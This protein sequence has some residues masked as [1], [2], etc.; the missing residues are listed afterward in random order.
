MSRFYTNAAH[1]F[2]RNPNYESTIFNRAWSRSSPFENTLRVLEDPETGRK[3]YLIGTTNSS[4][5][6][7]KRTE[8]LIAEV[9]PES[10]HVNTCSLWYERVSQLNISTQEQL[11]N[12]Q[13]EFTDILLYRVNSWPNNF[14]GVY[15][16]AR[17]YSWMLFMNYYLNFPTDFNPWRPGAE[18]L[19]GIKAAEKVGAKVN[20]FGGFLNGL[21][22]GRMSRENTI[23]LLSTYLRSIRG[24]PYSRWRTEAQDFWNLLKTT[25]GAA[26]SENLDSH[27]VSWFVKWLERQNPVMKKIM[28]D[29]ED[30]RMFHQIF[31]DPA[32]VS[33]AIVNHWHLPGIEA[34][35]RANTG[36]SHQGE[37]INPIGDMPIDEIME[38]GVEGDFLRAEYSRKSKTEPAAWSNYL[39]HYHKCVM[40]PER[41][42][43]VFFD[44]AH[45]HH[46]DHGLF[47]GENGAGH[48][49]GHHEEHHHTQVQGESSHAV[50]AETPKKSK[51]GK[52]QH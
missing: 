41:E 6:L 3:V 52:K 20:Y 24:E 45:D 18:V 49:D 4:T 47:N 13:G 10:I 19:W 31:E 2:M 28:V 9:K 34:M 11:N 37:R 22:V 39:T 8:Q 50:E 44:G 30:E 46:M 35:W 7:A 14:R 16:K 51:K 48:G 23:G 27:Y 25:G 29:T 43:H 17:V 1:R 36:T 33:V 12:L 42:R 32:K 5:T 21:V 26:F 38:A 40:E 15:F